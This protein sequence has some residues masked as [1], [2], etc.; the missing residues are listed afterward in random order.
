[1]PTHI[2]HPSR[3]RASGNPPKIIDEYI[4]QV[5]SET[6]EASVAHMRSPSGWSE[7]GQKP[8]FTEYSVVLKGMLKVE[9]RKGIIEVH[10]GEAII[11]EPGEWVRYS[12]P[13]DNGAEYISVCLPAF[14]PELLKRDKP[15]K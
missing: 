12:T 10:A 6:T 11:V 7:P 2:R 14:L 5:N 4:G 8:K 1:M 13:R 3:V 9:Y 15:K